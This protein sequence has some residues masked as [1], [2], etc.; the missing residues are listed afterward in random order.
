MSAVKAGGSAARSEHVQR[1]NRDLTHRPIDLSGLDLTHR[2]H[3]RR[4]HPRAV[5]TRTVVWLNHGDATTHAGDH[6][7]LHPVAQTHQTEAQEPT[8]HPPAGPT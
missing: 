3:R 5:P 4:N 1:S 2:H 8:R 7:P 6:L